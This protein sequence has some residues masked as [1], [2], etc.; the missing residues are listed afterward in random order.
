MHAS[1]EPPRSRNHAVSM[2]GRLALIV[3]PTLNRRFPARAP[4]DLAAKPS[5]RVRSLDSGW[6]HEHEN[7]RRARKPEGP[8]PMSAPSRAPRLCLTTLICWTVPSGIVRCSAPCLRWIWDSGSAA[9]WQTVPP[10]EIS[11][12]SRT[13]AGWW[14][15]V[16]TA[17]SRSWA[18]SQ[19]SVAPADVDPREV[20]EQPARMSRVAARSGPRH[21]MRTRTM[22]MW[23]RIMDSG[24][25]IEAPAGRGPIPLRSLGLGRRRPA[26]L[27]DS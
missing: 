4:R 25:A 7:T 26:L 9:G 24:R 22:R 20:V 6:H 10:V 8:R 5:T 17:R 27:A 21:R 16:T 3:C 12:A 18:R 23:V 19:W 1:N 14:R 13:D 15:R 2:L 11:P